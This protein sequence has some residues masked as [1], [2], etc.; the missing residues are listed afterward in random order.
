MSGFNWNPDSA[1]VNGFPV[2]PPPPPGADGG[3]GSVVE[4]ILNGLIKIIEMFQ[5]GIIQ[6]SA[7]ALAKLNALIGDLNKLKE[8]MNEVTGTG[9]LPS[10]WADQV[11]KV[12]KDINEKVDEL[13][14][15]NNGAYDSLKA[16]MKSGLDALNELFNSPFTS[17]F[18]GYLKDLKELEDFF[19]MLANYSGDAKDFAHKY[20]KQFYDLISD[21]AAKKD[22]LG[23]IV[24]D[25]KDMG[26]DDPN[27]PY[28]QMYQMFSSLKKESDSFWD[29]L[30]HIKEWRYSGVFGPASTKEMLEYVW[31]H[32]SDDDLHDIE[33]WLEA[34][35][36]Q[37]G[38][39][40]TDKDAYKYT[41]DSEHWSRFYDDGKLPYINAMR[42]AL[43]AAET[44][45]YSP[46][47]IGELLHQM[48]QEND[49]TDT[50]DLRHELG[51][52]WDEFQSA[53][54]GVN[55]DISAGESLNQQF[56]TDTNSKLTEY[57]AIVELLEQELNIPKMLVNNTL[58]RMQSG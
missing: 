24:D 28:Y 52:L 45:K 20:G 36:Y 29:G 3:M 47:L 56:V 49:P 25:F 54:S 18:E 38:K 27:S 12:M 46:Q 5:D 35:V 32:S 13:P 2:P 8:L 51:D 4:N 58:A 44:E 17:T 19:N 14:D 48:A 9:E 15:G 40:V 39:D 50:K 26:A 31:S 10:D 16:Q 22:A 57:K 6:P 37:H 43:N 34:A 7:D 30:M 33:V 55:S 53:V 11:S 42:D 23:A 1:T 21:L 41:F